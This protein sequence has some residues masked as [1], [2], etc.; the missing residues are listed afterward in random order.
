MWMTL[1]PYLASTKVAV[2]HVSDR[3]TCGERLYTY[4]PQRRDELLGWH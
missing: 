2:L 3:S 4:E 1:L